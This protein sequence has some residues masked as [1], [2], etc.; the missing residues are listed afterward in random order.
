MKRRA[1]IAALGG[2]AAWPLVA[3]AQQGERIRLIGVLI[4]YPENDP[5]GQVRATAF[6]QGLERLGWAV[7][8]N[9][10]IDFHWGLG[11]T[12][13]IRSAA[14]QLL[15]LAPDVIVANGDP[16]ARMM[17]QLSG[18]VPVIFITGSDPVEDG[19]VPTLARPGGNLTGFSVLEPSLGAK[20]LALLKE[21]A[22]HVAR[23]AVLL[24][25]DAS[26]L[27]FASTV[28]TACAPPTPGFRC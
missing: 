19:L 12:D 13:W 3:D 20:L 9:I 11:D 28:A 24:N 18:S 16:A 25:P 14:T 1:F 7:G 26:P 17:R 2:A 6:R 21:I 27:V 23:V 15:T 10:Q 5:E 8:R 4:L 22:P